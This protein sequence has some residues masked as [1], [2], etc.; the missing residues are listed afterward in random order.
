MGREIMGMVL[1]SGVALATLGAI[2]FHVYARSS[3]QL[4]M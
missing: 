2:S 1:L 4:R 3:G